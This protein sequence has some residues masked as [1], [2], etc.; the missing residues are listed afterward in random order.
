MI[1]AVQQNQNRVHVKIRR[2]KRALLSTLMI[3]SIVALAIP[4]WS[5]SPV[6]AASTAHT[7][8]LIVGDDNFTVAN[9]V[10]S[11]SGTENDPYIIENWDTSE[12]TIEDTDAYFV[13]RNCYVHDSPF[14]ITFRNVRN[15]KIDNATL[16]DTQGGIQFYYSH[17]NVI[18]NS[19]I[20]RNDIG[21][22]IS[23]SNC[24]H[25]ENC[26]INNNLIYGVYIEY[27]SST[28]IEDCIIDNN[29]RSGIRVNNSSVTNITNCA[30]KN[31]MNGI[32]ISFSELNPHI[33]NC[34]V[35]NN[36]FGIFLELAS[37]TTIA[38]CS[39]KNNQYG[40]H[41]Y[42]SPHN[43]IQNC[44][45]ENNHYGIGLDSSE[46][47]V[48]DCTFQNNAIDIYPESPTRLLLIVGIIIVVT[49][50]GVT[51]VLYVRRGHMKKVRKRVRH[52]RRGR[53]RK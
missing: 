42:F 28:D 44:I 21:I 39:V 23:A 20:E 15:G 31:S 24:N 50:I 4:L 32:Y 6:H 33:E 22:I 9:G 40:V 29:D 36:Y 16:D 8:I 26:T 25:I 5:P 14:G 12:I 52:K 35:E 7:P 43:W 3:I 17:N 48:I 2:F 18:A 46:I 1:Y 13:I 34:A 51:V 49:V 45:I 47:E 53:P 11:G 37:F 19:A 10:T 27:S 41:L 38:N 30:I